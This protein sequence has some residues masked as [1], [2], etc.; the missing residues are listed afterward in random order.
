[1]SPVQRREE[2]T[3]PDAVVRASQRVRRGRFRRLAA[4]QPTAAAKPTNASHAVRVRMRVKGGG[5]VVPCALGSTR[6]YRTRASVGTARRSSNN[7]GSGSGSTTEEAPPMGQGR[8]SSGTVLFHEARRVRN[9]LGK[10]GGFQAVTSRPGRIT[11]LSL[12]SRSGR[13]CV[14]LHAGETQQTDIGCASMRDD[15]SV[16]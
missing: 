11:R 12:A 14:S 2:V 7:S 16:R 3:R 4:A 15:D 5:G 10:Q 8:S 13:I 6:S 9:M 1:M